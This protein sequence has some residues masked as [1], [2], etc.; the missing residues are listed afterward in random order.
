MPRRPG[1]AVTSTHDPVPKWCC[2]HRHVLAALNLGAVIL[3]VASGGFSASLLGL[4]VSVTLTLAGVDD[5]PAIGLVLGIVS[6]L[7]IGGW[8]AGARARHSHRFHGA[9]TGLLL[10]FLIVVVARLGGSPAP[11]PT[12][13]WL[14]VLAV[15][16]SG[17]AGWLAGRKKAKMVSAS[18]SDGR[19][20]ET[21]ESPDS[22]GQGAG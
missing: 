6:G 5:G 10:A 9:V 19:G 14:A 21:E 16:I 15:L 8:V 18:S 3:G 13:V 7:A 12:V 22:K 2:H 17:L 11:T 4:L 1:N 20:R